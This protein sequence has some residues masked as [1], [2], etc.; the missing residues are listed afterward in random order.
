MF[1]SG[2]QR[3]DNLSEGQKHIRSIFGTARTISDREAE[4]LIKALGYL[5]LALTQASAY[6]REQSTCTVA[7]Y[8]AIYKARVNALNRNTTIDKSLIPFWAAWQI[9][10][11]EV[12][13]TPEASHLLS[14][15]AFLDSRA[16]P[17]FL[18]EAIAAGAC[19]QA[20]STLQQYALL[21]E[22]TEGSTPCR[23]W[24]IH[25]S[26]QIVLRSNVMQLAAG[27]TAE[28]ASA[29]VPVIPSS[30]SMA[31]QVIELLL[32]L[33]PEECQTA[34]DALRCR[35]LAPHILALRE[36]PIDS[37]VALNAIHCFRKSNFLLSIE[38]DQ[39]QQVGEL[40]EYALRIIKR[41]AGSTPNA[42]ALETLCHL[43]NVYYNLCEYQQAQ[44]LAE[45]AL[46]RGKQCKND[47]V[48]AQALLALGHVH[49]DLDQH[50]KAKECYEQALT[51]YKN[52]YGENADHPTIAST[53]HHLGSICFT[54]CDYTQ[55]KDYYEQLCRMEENIHGVQKNRRF[56]IASTLH[57]LGQ[58]YQALGNHTT[59]EEFYKKSLVHYE[60][61]L[62][63]CKKTYGESKNH[64]HIAMALNGLSEVYEALGDLTKIRDYH[65]QALH[66][67]EQALIMYKRIYGENANHS[68]IALTLNALGN[69][70]ES[71]NHHVE[72]QHYYRQA[73]AMEKA[74]RGENAKHRAFEIILF[75]SSHVCYQ[76]KQY[77]EAI[78]YSEQTLAME[79]RLYGEKADHTN[80]AATLNALGGAYGKLG[81]DKTAQNY[82]EQSLDMER[83]LH[84]QT[85]A[86]RA[87]AENLL[88]L[89][90]THNNQDQLEIAKSYLQQAYAMYLILPGY[91][92]NH[93]NTKKAKA[94]LD[95]HQWLNHAP[96]KEAQE[97][98][99]DFSKCLVM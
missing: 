26:V 13:K 8:I 75:A 84:G 46:D 65:E 68:S 7:Q 41:Q 24:R 21:T 18:L 67:L 81:Q 63:L 37:P 54:L 49:L 6:L 95:D 28:A 79:K 83:R 14:T 43:S 27:A 71:L 88:N 61:A 59:A 50:A 25:P 96:S 99:P 74:V 69:I 16:I 98:Q 19:G 78:H 97:T 92:A 22:N 47:H 20:I 3:F 48:I 52:L 55:A 45:T 39:A 72:A 91:G 93:P 9:S 38:Y 17:Q 10:M 64:T 56:N 73:L 33:W 32:K 2:T 77:R 1:F 23:S 30:L 90:V 11:K 15:C 51:L 31:S 87:I 53:L 4:D 35:T 40:C 70:H 94:W 80:I 29:E 76:L 36:L 66:H 5:S 42:D 86:N 60:Q 82:Y 57:Q 89:G 62:A 34:E 58:A 44:K 85:A 12:A